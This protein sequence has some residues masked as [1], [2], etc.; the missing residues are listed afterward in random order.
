MNI[1]FDGNFLIHKCFSVFSTY[2]RGQDM[3]E[4]LAKKE[5]Q[6]VFIRKCIIDLCAAVNKFTDVEKVVVT[7]DSSSWRYNL[8]ADYKY[9]LTKVRDAYYPQFLDLIKQLENLMRKRGLIVTRVSGAEGDDLMCIWSLFFDINDEPCVIITGD[10]DIRQ[11]ITKNVSV[12]NNHSKMLTMYCLP[13]NEVFW[14]EY[15]DADIQVVPIEPWK[16]LMQKVILGDKSD[17]V[18]QAKKG[19]GQKAFEKFIAQINKKFPKDKDLITT[20]TWIAQL[21]ADYT[22]EPYEEVLG[23]VLFNLKVTW[24]N[25]SVYNEIDYQTESGKSLL[26]TM[27]DEI[28]T[29][30]DTYTYNKEFTLEQFY[31]MMI[32]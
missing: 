29:L 13:G 6:Q 12:F 15:L 14:N 27:L 19:F 2:Y 31:G 25:V 3:C 10:S 11:L 20:A 16:I 32:K 9:S 23:K 8:Y 26:E 22:H 28:P 18:P 21:F 1:I 30:K 17:N 4:V 5:N 24:L 7:I